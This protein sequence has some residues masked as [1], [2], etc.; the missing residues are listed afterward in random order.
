[1]HRFI[2]LLFMVFLF[3][4]KS[5]SPTP[6]IRSLYPD[7][8][9]K[10]LEQFP[11]SC[12][13]QHCDENGNFYLDYLKNGHSEFYADEE[14]IEQLKPY[15]D[16]ISSSRKQC[17]FRICQNCHDPVIRGTFDE[18]SD[19]EE[20]KGVV[21]YRCTCSQEWCKPKDQKEYWVQCPYQAVPSIY[22][23]IRLKQFLTFF[24]NYLQYRKENPDCRCYCPF[25]NRTASKI[26]NFIFDEGIY[27]LGFLSLSHLIENKCDLP[28][29]PFIKN[30]TEFGAILS[31][32][33]N[34]FFYS[35]YRQVLLYLGQ[36]VESH[37]IS[38]NEVCDALDQIYSILEQLHP[39]FL[40]LYTQCLEKHPHPKIHYERGMILFHEG[41][42]STSLDD[43]Q[44]F[45]EFSE[46]RYEGLLSSPLYLQE[47]SCYAEL[48]LYDKAVEN[49]TEAISRDPKNQKAYFERAAAYFE[50]GNFDLSLE[51]YLKSNLKPY[52]SAINYPY[53]APFAQAL[54][55]GILSG[56]VEGG[57][58]LLS[59]IKTLGRTIWAFVEDPVEISTSFFNAAKECAEFVIKSTPLE[60]VDALVPEFQTLREDWNKINEAK[61]CEMIGFII[62]KYGVE[63]FAG[64]TI[65]KGFK[66]YQD[67]RKANRLMTFEA[68]AISERN[69]LIIKFEATKQV[70]ARKEILANANLK[71]HWDKQGKHIVGHRNYD[72]SM[73]RSIF[74]HADPQRLS[75]EFAGKGIRMKDM[76]PGMPGYKEVVD[77][78]EFIGYYFDFSTREKIPTTR[79][80]I[81]Y[82]KDGVHIVP[83]KPK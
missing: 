3:P 36:Y 68:M 43:I 65:V 49:L 67:L 24:K 60:L 38:T 57:A 13:E 70:R 58:S 55:T 56:G 64:S 34:A 74:V 6:L 22:F 40:D 83:A 32:F 39:L 79:G 41:M 29:F 82:A 69:Q 33:G 9:L 47:G 25:N 15:F 18:E 8:C 66:A 31:L 26:S 46:P 77:F 16:L 81:H 1:M 4:L 23:D 21:F 11:S 35:Q 63:L 14:I 19:D 30:S 59:S 80:T 27:L 17:D 2:T 37:E 72:L 7:F 42:I 53:L 51:D 10:H 50:L 54:K 20:S 71:I 5:E 62:G 76:H 75:N 28:E 52:P 12:S 73:R 44:S 61:R 48:G 45:T 78:N